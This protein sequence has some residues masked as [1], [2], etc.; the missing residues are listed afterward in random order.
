MEAIVTAR[1][2]AAD[3]VVLLQHE[4]LDAPARERGRGRQPGGTAADHDDAWM[5]HVA[6]M[7]PDGA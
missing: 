4:G 5:R 2:C 1:P 7:V 6:G 3:G